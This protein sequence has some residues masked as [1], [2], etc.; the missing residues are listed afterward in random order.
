LA[1][2]IDSLNRILAPLAGGLLLALL[3]PR[4]PGLVAAALATLSAWYGWRRLV[5]EDCLSLS[6]LPGACDA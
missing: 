6:A 4:S 2:S 3:G 1:A 5:T